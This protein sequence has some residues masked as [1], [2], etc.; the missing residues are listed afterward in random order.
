MTHRLAAGSLTNSWWQTLWWQ[1]SLYEMWACCLALYVPPILLLTYASLFSP[2]VLCRWF[3]AVITQSLWG[4][5]TA[6]RFS[7]VSAPHLSSPVRP[8]PRCAQG[9]SG[10]GQLPCCPA[11][12][13][14]C[15]RMAVEL[16]RDW[17]CVK[18]NSRF[19]ADISCNLCVSVCGLCWSF[20]QCQQ[21][22]CTAW[23][24]A[25]RDVHSHII[26]KWDGW[27]NDRQATVLFAYMDSIF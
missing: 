15:I 12:W 20:S 13:V 14:L 27:Q 11:L 17:I 22:S 23:Q 18:S 9:T 4:T 26:T 2:S 6:S 16:P 3:I 8:A 24:N 19:L 21:L 10:V 5:V 1:I 7:G 25:T